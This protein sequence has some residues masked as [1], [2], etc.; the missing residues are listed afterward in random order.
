MVPNAIRKLNENPRK[1]SSLAAI[2]SFMRDE[3]GIEIKPTIATKIKNFILNAVEDGDLIQTKGKGANGR[4]TVKGMKRKVKKRRKK[5]VVSDDEGAVDEA[6]Y[7]PVK[8][9]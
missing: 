8:S 4:F 9:A 6:E 1:G 5:V 7:N 3:W 2:K